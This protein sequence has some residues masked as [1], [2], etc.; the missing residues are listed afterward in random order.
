MLPSMEKPMNILISDTGHETSSILAVHLM[1]SHLANGFKVLFLS[2][3]EPFTYYNSIAVKMKKNIQNHVT[4]KELV[5]IDGLQL[6]KSAGLIGTI[7]P[8]KLAGHPYNFVF[9]SKSMDNLLGAING[10]TRSWK[11]TNSKYLV[12]IE[13]MNCFMNFGLSVDDLDRFYNKL[14]CMLADKSLGSLLVS[15]RLLNE[16]VGLC[17]NQRLLKRMQLHL[18][19]ENLPTG[20][21]KGV[22]GCLKISPTT[23]SSLYHFKMTDREIKVFPPGL[24]ANLV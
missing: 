4:N 22:D 18:L 1:C 3:L 13:G 7:D 20:K 2:N 11:E 15:N 14:L 5:F 24:G 9:G 19:V 6:I 21:C 12:L 16:K 23:S 10:V 8:G 17:L